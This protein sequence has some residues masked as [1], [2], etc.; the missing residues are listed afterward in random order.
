VCAMVF[1]TWAPADDRPET[2]SD[3]VFVNPSISHQTGSRV[4]RYGICMAGRSRG[5]KCGRLSLGLWSHDRSLNADQLLQVASPQ[6]THKIQP[7][8]KG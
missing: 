2:K 7:D 6:S 8:T 1:Y 3:Q 5:G 4:T